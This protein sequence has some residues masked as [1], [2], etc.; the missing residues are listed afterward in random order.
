MRSMLHARSRLASPAGLRIGA[1]IALLVFGFVLG[2]RLVSAGPPDTQ[3]RL[4]TLAEARL[5][6]GHEVPQVHFVQPAFVLSSVAVD[7]QQ[8]ANRGVHLTYALQNQNVVALSVYRVNT[9]ER[10]GT[11]QFQT[12]DLN[13]VTAQ[14]SQKTIDDWQAVTYT[15]SRAGLSHVLHVKLTAGLTR[16]FADRIAQS[17]N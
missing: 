13:G 4:T 3:A 7:P 16:D 11:E 2:D 5:V 10:I 15:W 6:L 8:S 1:T 17:V 14:V 9:I 12:L